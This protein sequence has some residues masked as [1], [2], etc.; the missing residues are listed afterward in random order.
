M[1]FASPLWL[2]TLL[3]IPLLIAAAVLLRN[4][5]NRYAIRFPAAVSLAKAAESVKTPLQ[6]A[7]AVLAILGLGLLGLSL[8][9]P[10]H[11]TRV[12]IEGATVILVTDHSY[13]MSATDVQP[14][15]L[16]AATS[17]AISFLAATPRSARV[18]LVTYS[19]APDQALQPSRDH[20]AVR[21]GLE[22]Q[23]P[24]GGTATGTALQVALDMVRRTS[25]GHGPT[26]AIVL[27]SDG[28]TNVGR[29]PLLVAREAR[30]QQVPIS[31]VALGTSSATIPNPN[32]PTLPAIAVPPDPETLSEIAQLSGGRAF[33][34]ADSN[35]LT[36]IYESLGSSLATRAESRDITERFAAAGLI[37]LLAAGLASVALAGRIP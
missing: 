8:G 10:K 16:G 24:Q 22:A 20:G 1:S 28:S 36:S 15:R 30:T 37:A 11:E 4:R 31:T 29:D 3:A 7:P 5:Q 33:T 6:H 9:R 18:G 25:R 27:L 2:L 12:P 14:T 23:D 17:A 35:R 32:D 34:T 13:S 19:D 26:A 21:Q